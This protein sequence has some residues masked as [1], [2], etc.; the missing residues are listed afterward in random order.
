MAENWQMSSNK[1]L[2]DEEG[3]TRRV[4]PK[5]GNLG[6][7][8]LVGTEIT[9]S[10]QLQIAIAFGNSSEAPSNILLVCPRCKCN[11]GVCRFPGNIGHL[12]V[13]EEE[14]LENVSSSSSSSSST[15]SSSSR[16]VIKNGNSIVKEEEE[17]P[18]YGPFE[19]TSEQRIASLLEHLKH[20][21][22][23][24]LLGTLPIIN[25]ISMH[26][27]KCTAEQ[28]L[29]AFVVNSMTSKE[30]ALKELAEL[31]VFWGCW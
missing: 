24:N 27:F 22:E 19:G 14:D 11:K 31:M 1:H 9:S 30:S 18:P 15:S 6:E 4:K 20:Y 16:H 17:D 21:E 12:I 3:E 5:L 29:N 2:R 25:R 13:K 26:C 7:G 28:R 10:K 8:I 23:A